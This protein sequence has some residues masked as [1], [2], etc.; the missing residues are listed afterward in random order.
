LKF[1]NFNKYLNKQHEGGFSSLRTLK[2]NSA[3]SPFKNSST[4]YAYENLDEE[5]PVMKLNDSAQVLIVD[6]IPM[7]IIALSA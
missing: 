5:S 6:D 7:N 4:L 1:S 2:I 3:I